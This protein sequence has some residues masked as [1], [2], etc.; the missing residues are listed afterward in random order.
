MPSQK[1]WY[2]G[3]RQLGHWTIEH[4]IGEGNTAAVF[5][6]TRAGQVAELKV[7]KPEFSQ[8]ED[9]NERFK[10]QLELKVHGHPHLVNILDGGLDRGCLYLVMKEVK[11]DSLN[12]L[13][14]T[15]HV[16]RIQAILAQIASAAQFL[17]ERGIVHRD[18]KPSNIIV[19]FAWRSAT[20]VDLGVI[21]PILT[22]SDASLRSGK[23]LGT[24]RYTPH[25]FLERDFTDPERIKKKPIPDAAYRA[26]TFYQLG[27]VAYELITGSRF[28]KDLS[29]EDNPATIL[30]KIK[31]H[32]L[33]LS[34]GNLR[35]DVPPELVDLTRRCLV[36]DWEGGISLN[37]ANFERRLFV[38]KPTVVL[39]YTG[40]TIGAKTENDD[41]TTRKL[42]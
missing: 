32:D 37:W 31:S 17:E 40:G 13:I 24:L 26:L 42:R 1:K 27:A 8:D 38:R 35:R 21:R 4:K 20:L 23:N 39:L 16:Y 25:E 36:T 9:E 34:P 41:P 28:L 2:D 18:I 6:A 5:H 33:D 14:G 15:L 19:D 10:R 29:T 3:F 22:S 30:D 11:G 7:Y 12:H